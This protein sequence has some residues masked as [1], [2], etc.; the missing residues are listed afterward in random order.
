MHIDSQVPQGSKAIEIR[1]DILSRCEVAASGHDVLGV[2]R[3]SGD[4]LPGPA[5]RDAQPDAGWQD[6]DLRRAIAIAQEAGLASYRIEIA[7]DGTI[8]IT[9]ASRQ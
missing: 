4:G 5:K 8:T 9:V 7:P 2:S 3:M 6:A 1:A